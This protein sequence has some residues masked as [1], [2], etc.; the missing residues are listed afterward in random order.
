MTRQPP[1]EPS[2][3][4]AQASRCSC[5]CNQRGSDSRCIPTLDN[6]ATR[7]RRFSR[8]ISATERGCVTRAEKSLLDKTARGSS[9]EKKSPELMSIPRSPKCVIPRPTI[10]DP[11]PFER[12]RWRR[13]AY[14]N[15]ATVQS[16]S[17]K[18]LAPVLAQDPPLATGDKTRDGAQSGTSQNGA[19]QMSPAPRLVSACTS[20]AVR[21]PAYRASL[22]TVRGDLSSISRRPTR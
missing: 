10:R 18:A 21:S 8:R 3:A 6:T 19:R 11:F 5:A 20:Q 17:K 1:F 16:P 7:A 22:R 2:K 4:V 9:C 13:I 12:S 15:D 14:P